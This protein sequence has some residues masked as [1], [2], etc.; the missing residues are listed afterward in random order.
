MVGNPPFL[1]GKRQRAVLGD[2]YVEALQRTYRGRVHGEADLACY[3]IAKAWAQIEEGAAERAGLVVTGSVRGGRSRG[4]LDRIAQ[5]GTIFEAWTEVPWAG[6]LRANRG[7]VFTGIVRNGPFDVA[8]EVA[9]EWLR[10]AHGRANAA[11][12]RPWWSG[13]DVV[14]RPADRWIVDFGA[15]MGE[16]GAAR[17]AEPFRYVEAHVKPLRE[18]SR[19]R[20]ARE[21][22]W[23]CE[24]ARTGMRSA[25][26]GLARCI[27]T[28]ALAK[29]RV[30]AWLD[31]RI[32]PDHQLVVIARDDDTTFGVLQSRFHTAWALRLGTRLEDRPRYTPT[33]VFETFPFPEGLGPDR[34]AAD[35]AEEPRAK[36]IAAAAR[37][38]AAQRARWLDPPEWVQRVEEEA[39][40]YP[41]RAMAR[42]PGAARALKERTLTRLYNGQ[43]GWLVEAHR[44]L[45][46]AVARAYGWA[47][48]AGEETALERLRALNAERAEAE[49]KEE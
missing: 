12:L 17:Y 46:R 37:A 28:P 25:L 8:G 20:A 22:W 49:G 35:Y 41:S 45:D 16:R 31:T 32:C 36:E 43:P 27:V 38:L 19:R 30:F 14:Q 40:G 3:W 1:G 48:E 10:G 5:R 15:T 26:A 34:P 39:P 4:V 9:R 24:G 6:R 13:R 18:R 33:T 42:G 7:A 44:A 11:V 2:G 23:R 29:H 47:E 21:R